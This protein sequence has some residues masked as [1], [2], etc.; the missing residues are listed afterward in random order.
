DSLI[1]QIIIIA[2]VTVLFMA[3][4]WSGIGKGIKYLSNTNMVLAITLLILVIILGPTLL[5]FNMFTDS[6]GNYFQNLIN[7]S[8]R[9]APIDGENRS[10]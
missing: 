6:L 8:F 9:A 10:W 5:I 1:T 7:M 2:V 4:A 3:S